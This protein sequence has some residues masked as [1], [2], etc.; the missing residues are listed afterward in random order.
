MNTSIKRALTSCFGLGLSPFA[1][2]TCGSALPVGLFL[3][4]VFLG[5]NTTLLASFLIVSGLFFSVVCVKFTPAIATLAGKKDPG[6]IVADEYAGQVV[7]LLGAFFISS[8]YNPLTVGILCFLLFRLFDIIKPFPVRELEKLPNGFG[9]LADD[10]FAGIYGA[11]CLIIFDSLGWIT[12]L[13][14]LLFAGEGL[15]IG[16]AVILGIVQGLT[17]FLPVSSSGHL[18]FFEY[19]IPTLDPNTPQMLL[20]DLAI[21]VA[22]LVAIIGIYIKDIKGLAVGLFDVKRYEYKPLRIW[23]ENT[24]WRFALCVVIST[25]T[26]VI[27]YKLFKEQFREA[28]HLPVVVAMWFITGT[29]LILTDRKKDTH[30]GLVNFGIMA[31]IIIGIAQAAAILPGISRS[32][33]T[34]CAAVFL[35]FNR[36]WAVEYS[37]MIAIPAI[38]GGTILEFLEHPEIIGSEALPYNAIISGM[39]AACLVGIAALKL[40]IYLSEKKN[41]KVF[42]IYCYCIATVSLIYLFT[43]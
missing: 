6:E 41:L 30:K 28:R 15:T 14:T 8:F 39:V 9:V 34:I 24:A 43:K 31:A 13:D 22:T 33:A 5:L 25:L 16:Y 38:V 18:V 32:G 20:F 29:F 12:A 21:H 10:I 19:F 7:T 17:E 42:G 3:L 36:K 23:K 40:L 37:F 27:L 11:I 26:T 1:P 4:G 35:G 2:G